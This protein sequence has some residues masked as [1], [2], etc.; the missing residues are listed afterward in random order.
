MDFSE[1]PRDEQWVDSD[2][3]DSEPAKRRRLSFWVFMVTGLGLLAMGL[4]LVVVV[5]PV[6]RAASPAAERMTSNNHL[7]QIGLALHHYHNQHGSFPPA[8]IADEEGRP[9]HSWRVL[10]LPYAGEQA[11][12]DRY[13]FDKPW[14]HPNNVEVTRQMPEIYGSPHSHYYGFG[15][16]APAGHTHYQA[17]SAPGTVL[18]QTEGCR[19]DEIADG[20]FKTAIVLENYA[21]PVHWA[22]P[23]D[24]SPRDIRANFE[25]ITS[26]PSSGSLVLMADGSIRTITAETTPDELEGGFY[27]D[28]G[29]GFDP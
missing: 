26:G 7:K 17:I 15:K 2:P 19:M 6:G 11:L 10:I 25:Q 16:T 3:T 23:T 24:L 21:R 13:D 27:I 5:I 18:G 20:L 8:Y 22:E 4:V 1:P 28:D 12:Y 29:R 14:D 9:M